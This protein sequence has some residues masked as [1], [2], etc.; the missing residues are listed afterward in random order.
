MKA[1]AHLSVAVSNNVAVFSMP[2]HPGWMNFLGASCTACCE[3]GSSAATFT[4]TAKPGEDAVVVIMTTH[5]QTSK[6]GGFDD[7]L[8]VIPITWN[9][10]KMIV[11]LEKPFLS[12]SDRLLNVSKTVTTG[13]SLMVTTRGQKFIYTKTPP[14]EGVEGMRLVANA[15][16]LLGYAVGH[17]SFESL[18]AAATLDKRSLEE[19]EKTEA[20]ARLG[21]A[22]SEISEL[23]RQL[24]NSASES[25]EARRYLSE[26]LVQLNQANSL[27]NTLTS[28]KEV[29]SEIILAVTDALW[30]TGAAKTRFGF[31]WWTKLAKIRAA[32]E[33]KK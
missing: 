9:Q 28:T 6:G 26:T 22:E 29:L 27:V 25:T 21:Q 4:I 16:T 14:A 23:Q 15:T 12:M 13:T 17:V 32:Y 11:D 7:N 1:S 3:A 8:C 5:K 18:E 33:L 30:N 20:L 24:K 19:R 2:F 10:G 31:L